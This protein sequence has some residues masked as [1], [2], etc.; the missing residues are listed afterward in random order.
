MK[1]LRL[2]KEVLKVFLNAVMD[3]YE[4]IAP[5]SKDLVRFEKISDVNDIYLEKNYFVAP[6]NEKDKA[7]FLFRDAITDTA[8]RAIGDFVMH[9]KE[10]LCAIRNY[11]SG[12]LL[13]TLRFADEV[14]DIGTIDAL[15]SKVKITE[16]EMELA[17]ELISKL[18]MKSFDL[19]EYKE[20]FSQE[21]KNLIKRKLAGEKII[22]EKPKAKKEENLIKALKASIK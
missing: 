15:N 9:E 19:S 1:L 22:V 21:L 18:D 5:V 2:E 3:G 16:A 20:T 11:K 17:K 4:L 6:Q 13:T 10:H 14:R 7:F 8:K 12:M